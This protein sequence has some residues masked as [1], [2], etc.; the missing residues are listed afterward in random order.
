MYLRNIDQPISKFKNR[1]D[2]SQGK[3]SSENTKNKSKNIREEEPMDVEPLEELTTNN[4]KD[5]RSNDKEQ[6]KQEHWAWLENIFQRVVST[7]N[8]QN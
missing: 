6:L 1:T 3:F 7:S 8:N 4:P 2:D 5:M